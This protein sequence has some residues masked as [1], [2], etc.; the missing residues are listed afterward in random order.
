VDV[1]TSLEGRI[2]EER[3]FT[4]FLPQGYATPTWIHVADEE[5]ENTYTLIIHPLT[6]KTEIR[7]GR[8]EMQRQGL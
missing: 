4:R 5:G 2:T 3:A 1:E 7:D 8:V 6:G